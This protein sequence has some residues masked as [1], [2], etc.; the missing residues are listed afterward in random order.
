[1]KF[2]DMTYSNLSYPYIQFAEQYEHQRVLEKIARELK[3][4]GIDLAD[5]QCY[6]RYT[7]SIDLTA[8]DIRYIQNFLKF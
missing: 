6:I 8:E 1:M 5:A 4:H 7:Y 3:Y 2:V